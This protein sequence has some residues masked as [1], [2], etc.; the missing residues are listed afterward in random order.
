MQTFGRIGAEMGPPFE[1]DRTGL[2]IPCIVNSFLNGGL[3]FI[4]AVGELADGKSLAALADQIAIDLGFGDR[5]D[6]LAP[7]AFAGNYIRMVLNNF[8]YV[9]HGRS[10]MID[11]RRTKALRGPGGRAR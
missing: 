9:R 6:V 8:L 11:M 3:S 10:L 2:P 7:A 5:D 1:D 4:G